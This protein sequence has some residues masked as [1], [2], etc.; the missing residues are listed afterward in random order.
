MIDENYA[1]K[2]LEVIGKDDFDSVIKCFDEKKLSFYAMKVL[3][4]QNYDLIKV[5]KEI[6]TA[7]RLT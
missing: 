6:E 4:I 7:I 1:L 2:E 3:R 5:T